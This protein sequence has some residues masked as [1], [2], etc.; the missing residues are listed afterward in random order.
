MTPPVRYFAPVI[1]DLQG[2]RH[3]MAIAQQLRDGG[4]VTILPFTG[5]THSTLYIGHTIRMYLTSSGQL[6]AEV[7][8]EGTTR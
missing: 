1:I 8:H 4:E 2:H 6:S 7:I 5:E 3:T